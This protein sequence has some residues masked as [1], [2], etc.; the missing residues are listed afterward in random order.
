MAIDMISRNETPDGLT[1]VEYSGKST[2]SKP[3][4]VNFASGSVF[5]EVDTGD[6]YLYD[7]EGSEWNKV[8][9]SDE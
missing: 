3:T 6:A 2:D 9:E 1:Y 7:R 4:S 5:L 8:G